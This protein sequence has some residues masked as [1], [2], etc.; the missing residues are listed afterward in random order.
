MSHRGRRRPRRGRSA[1]FR[2]RGRDLRPSPAGPVSRGRPAPRTS[3]CCSAGRTSAGLRP[4]VA[5]RRDPRPA[6]H[7]M[8]VSLGSPRSSLV[9][10]HVVVLR[11]NGSSAEAAGPSRLERVPRPG[12]EGRGRARLGPRLRCAARGCAA[13]RSMPAVVGATA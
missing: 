13:S 5:A 9:R 7:A 10:P 6:P 8:V 11:A 12:S 1:A 2:G 4:S 3:S